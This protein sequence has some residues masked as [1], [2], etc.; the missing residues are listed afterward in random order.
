MTFRAG[1][2]ASSEVGVI[3]NDVLRSVRYMLDISETT[4]VE[5]VALGDG[6]VSKGA[7]NVYLKREDEDGFQPCPDEV[8]ARF[9]NGLVIY[10]R[11]RE[12]GRPAPALD[13]PLTNNTSLKKLRV[14]FNLKEDDMFAVFELAGFR[15]TK[16]E[17]SSFFRKEGQRNYRGCGDQILRNFL[18]GLTLRVRPG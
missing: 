13:L 18:K 11:G 12:E 5:I 7:I 3:N 15:V 10:R 2:G 1:T 9:L 4:I 17:L 6:S 16:P 8:M 14:A